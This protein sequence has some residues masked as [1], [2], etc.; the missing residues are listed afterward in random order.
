MIGDFGDPL[1]TDTYTVCLYDESGASPSLI[2]RMTA[3]AGGVCGSR[4]CWR[5]VGD[6]GLA[7][8]D[9]ERTP[10]GVDTARVT[11]N[12]RGG[13]RLSV[14]GKGVNLSNRAVPL[15]VP[16][17]SLPLRAQ[18]QVG[19]GEC[20]EATYDAASRNSPGLFKG[21]AE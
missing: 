13:V 3:P 19:N 8:K 16:P 20:W 7:Y 21:A 10:E 11:V 18:L 5:R 14:K 15:L 12:A 4:S 1:D 17:L 2:F 6:G 9:K